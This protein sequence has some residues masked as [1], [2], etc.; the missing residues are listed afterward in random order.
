MDQSLEKFHTILK[1]LGKITTIQQDL[2]DEYTQ[3]NLR[4]VYDDVIEDIENLIDESSATITTDFQIETI[5]YARKHVRSIFYNLLSNAIKYR[6]PE[7]IPQIKVRCYEEKESIVLSVKD[8][9]RG[10]SSS[11]KERMFSLFQ[12]FH[13]DV[14]GSGIGLYMLKRIITNSGGSI[15]IESNEGMGTEFKVYLKKVEIDW[16]VDEKWEN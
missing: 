4:E 11:Q 15:A 6:S 7:R 8:N 14:E 12:R 9:G 10:L 3:I 16:S 1:D 13:K 2:Q 5:V